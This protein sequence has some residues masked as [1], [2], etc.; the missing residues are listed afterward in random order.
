MREIMWSVKGALNVIAVVLV[1]VDLPYWTSKVEHSIAF[2]AIFSNIFTAHAKFRRLGDVFHWFLH[3]IC[4]KS[5][6]FLPT[7]I[8]QFIIEQFLGYDEIKGR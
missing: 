5:F 1:D 4:W 8:S 6:I 7:P 2:T 3:F